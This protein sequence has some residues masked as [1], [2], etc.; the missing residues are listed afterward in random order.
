MPVWNL[1]CRCIVG[2]RIT[3]YNVQGI[4]PSK[5]TA[6]EPVPLAAFSF[7]GCANGRRGPASIVLISILLSRGTFSH[8]PVVS[9]S[10]NEVQGVGTDT[11]KKLFILKKNRKHIQRALIFR[12]NE[13]L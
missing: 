4:I 7:A 9:L 6:G 2:H 12:T 1:P 3:A 10:S 5:S 11:E 13:G 8:R